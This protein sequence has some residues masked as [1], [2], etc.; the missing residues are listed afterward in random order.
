MKRN[1]KSTKRLLMAGILMELL[2]GCPMRPDVRADLEGLTAEKLARFGTEQDFDD[3]VKRMTDVRRRY[4]WQAPPAVGCADQAAPSESAQ[5]DGAAPAQ[6][7]ITNNQEQG[8]DEG[9]IVKAHGDFLVVLRRGRLFTVRLADAAQPTLLPVDRINAFPEGFTQG[10]WYDEMLIH[11]DRVVVIGY[12]YQVSATELGLFRLGDDGT[13]THEDTYFLR[14][15]DY[16][17]SRNYASRLVEGKLILYMPIPMFGGGGLLGEGE[18]AVLPSVKK[19]VQGNETTEWNQI[20]NKVEVF[21]PVQRTVEPVLHTV[22]QCD[23][24]QEEPQCTA[25]A[26][27]G[28]Y[29]RSFYV[30]GEAVY[31]WVGPA[32]EDDDGKGPSFLYRMPLR[33]GDVTAARVHAMPIDQFSFKEDADGFINVLLSDVGGGDEMWNPEINAGDMAL[34]RAPLSELNADL[35]ELSDERYTKVPSAGSAYS[36]QNRFVGNHV[37][38]GSGGGWFA[39][40]EGAERRVFVTEYSNA[41]SVREVP[42]SHGVDRIEVLG[43]AAMVVGVGDDALRFSAISLGETP[44]VVSTFSKEGARQGETRSHGFFFKPDGTGGGILGLPARLD[45]EAYRHLTHGSAEVVFLK[46][47][48]ALQLVNLG[49]LVAANTQQPDDEC[50]A[51]CVD[52]YG[53]A[54]PIFL[55]GRIYALLGY[56]LVEGDLR[57]DAMREID[58]ADFLAVTAE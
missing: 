5:A 19:W 37:L 23:L 22:V 20:L 40:G 17:S 13:L 31:V 32:Y 2:F 45:G 51:S 34:L 52:W 42:L 16:Y 8:V 39:T 26:V 50:T 54:R 27:L 58:R 55:G 44:A 24:E 28:P 6:E 41:G 29:A 15:N 48:P 3:Y 53:N 11:G 30:S 49:S 7:S 10:T 18:E 1:W 47:T 56:E 43:D 38:W 25:R 35:P 21:R 57:D 9:D 46:V 33:G 4:Y 12:S 36:R 14:S